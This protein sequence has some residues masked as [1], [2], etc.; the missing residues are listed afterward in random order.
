MIGVDDGVPAPLGAHFDGRGV[1]FALFSQ[2]ATA[3]DLCLFDAGERHE[4]RRIRLPCRTDDVWHGYL[5]GVFPGQL[6]GTVSMVP[7]ILRKATASIPPN[8]SWTPMLATFR[9][10]SAG[11]IHSTA[12]AAASS[13]PIRSIGAT[14]PHSCRV[15]SS[16]RQRYRTSR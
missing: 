10:A 11:T 16:R 9:V 1:N 5:R 12:I 2:N 7:G 8:C 13:V 3:V 14:A 4:T 15:A 6:T